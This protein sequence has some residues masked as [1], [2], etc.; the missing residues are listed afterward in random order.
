MNNQHHAFS[1]EVKYYVSVCALQVS[2]IYWVKTI[3]LSLFQ[4]CHCT[5]KCKKKTT[6]LFINGIHCVRDVRE[7]YKLDWNGFKRIKRIFIF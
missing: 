3:L 7:S 5:L 4:F 2:S 1:P 6:M